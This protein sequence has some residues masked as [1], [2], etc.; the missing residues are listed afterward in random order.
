MEFYIPARR[1][2]DAI[3]ALVLLEEGLGVSDGAI[4][5]LKA[6]AA[7]ADGNI[8]DAETFAKQAT[9]AEPALEVAWWSL[10]RVRTRAE[11][12]A[13]AIEAMTRLEDDFGENLDPQT[14][15]KDRFLKILADKPEY[16]AWRS[17]RD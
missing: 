10:L 17:S 11:D 15:G 3:D 12:Y 2:K 14:L 6:M 13:G 8:E 5:S 1:Y 16:L 4:G 7:L 9:E